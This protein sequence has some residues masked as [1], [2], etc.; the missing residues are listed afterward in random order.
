MSEE[1]K[2]Q[3]RGPKNEGQG[4]K[5]LHNSQG[6]KWRVGSWV[7]YKDDGAIPVKKKN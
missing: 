3:G 7:K 4:K 1:S 6:A 2:D 5:K